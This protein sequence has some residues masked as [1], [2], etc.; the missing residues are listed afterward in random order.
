MSVQLDGNNP[1]FCRYYK[2]SKTKQCS[3]LARWSATPRAKYPEL[4]KVHKLNTHTYDWFENNGGY[5]KD[6]VNKEVGDATSPALEPDS[7]ALKEALG[8]DPGHS[9]DEGSGTDSA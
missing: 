3:N 1:R 5:H 4:C 9:S 6:D 7:M 8:S 2:S